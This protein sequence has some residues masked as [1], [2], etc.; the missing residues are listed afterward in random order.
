MEFLCVASLGPRANGLAFV[1]NTPKFLYWNNG[2]GGEPPRI[3]DRPAD[4]CLG[5]FNDLFTQGVPQ[6]LTL[7]GQ[8]AQQGECQKCD[9][10]VEPGVRQFQ[11]RNHRG[12]TDEAKHPA[13]T[14][15]QEQF[16]PHGPFPRATNDRGQGK[17]GHRVLWEEAGDK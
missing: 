2:V 7:P 11:E 15:D 16:Q 12:T 10:A 17:V 6:F 4:L 14:D 8:S 5:N 9:R 13:E 3:D 1:P